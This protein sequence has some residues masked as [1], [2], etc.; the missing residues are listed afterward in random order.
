[1]LVGDLVQILR[2]IYVLSRVYLQRLAGLQELL[3]GLLLHC[4]VAIY[5]FAFVLRA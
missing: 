3:G 2:Q 1:M 5:V 4:E